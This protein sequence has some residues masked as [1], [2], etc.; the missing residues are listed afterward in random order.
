MRFF[1]IVLLAVTFLTNS[2]AA[3]GL[4]S[5]V[6]H[7]ND[8]VVTRYELNQRVALLQALGARGD[9]R[10]QAID[11]LIGD[12]LRVAEAARSGITLSEE[13][14]Q[15]AMQ[16]FAERN[17]QTLDTVLNLLASNGVA[18]EAL[19]DLVSANLVWQTLVR[20]RFSSATS[21]SEAEVDA[22][23]SATGETTNLQVLVTEIVLPLIEGQE[24]EIRQLARD[25]AQIRSQSEFEAAAR[26]FSVAQSRADSGKLDWI[27][28][29]NLPPALRPVLLPLGVGQVSTPLELPNAI[30]LF[31]MR[32]LSE[33][34]PTS[35]AIVSVEYAVVSAPASDAAEA[36]FA[37]AS[38]RALRCD[39]LYG[40]TAGVDGATV[41]INA[42]PPND[43]PRQTALWLA[44]LDAGESLIERTSSGADETLHLAML[45]SRTAAANADVSRDQ[46]RVRLLNEKLTAR[47]ESLLDGLRATARI[48]LK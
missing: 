18:T 10:E 32:G 24:A 19:R 48:D 1:S 30:A 2:V 3:Q 8:S 23:L 44:R 47:A 6:A 39:D 43:I 13:Q 41:A 14:I 28:L 42:Q 11:G 15:V 34:A 16:Q 36:G 7:V 37:K 35:G 21:V 20:Q 17:G 38:N 25:I 26:Q 5:P 29:S 4:F 22:A 9:L 27:S 40:L 45:C 33:T 12:R 31:Q 46:V